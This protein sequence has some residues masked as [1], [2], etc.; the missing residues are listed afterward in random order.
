MSR[1]TQTTR[2]TLTDVLQRQI[3]QVYFYLRR[4]SS[5][6]T[7]GGPTTP[8]QSSPHFRHPRSWIVFHFHHLVK[9]IHRILTL[10][11]TVFTC[12]LCYLQVVAVDRVLWP[13]GSMDH[14]DSRLVPKLKS[15]SSESVGGVALRA[16]CSKMT[17]SKQLQTQLS[18]RSS[19]LPKD[20]WHRQE[21]IFFTATPSVYPEGACWLQGS[22]DSTTFRFETEL[23]WTQHFERVTCHLPTKRTIN[24]DGFEGD[25]QKRGAAFWLLIEGRLAPSGFIFILSPTTAKSHGECLLQGSTAEST[26]GGKVD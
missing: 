22:F 15:F 12:L 19:Y 23:S 21:F 24:C 14:R 17:G 2:A 18:S 3:I 9:M 20:G 5:K 16:T 11:A 26:V 25:K 6:E 10:C 4:A 8:A 13:K 7:G 1:P